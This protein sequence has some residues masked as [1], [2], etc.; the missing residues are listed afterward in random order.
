MKSNLCNI[1]I[2]FWNPGKSSC[3]V[4]QLLGND[5]FIC[6]LSLVQYCAV[7]HVYQH[8]VLCQFYTSSWA[9]L[10]AHMKILGGR[11]KCQQHNTYWPHGYFSNGYDSWMSRQMRMFI[12]V[13]FWW[14]RIIETQQSCLTLSAENLG[15]SRTYSLGSLYHL[16]LVRVVQWRMY[17]SIH[18][19]VLLSC[20]KCTHEDVGGKESANNKHIQ[21]VHWFSYLT[22]RALC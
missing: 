3:I 16:P 11:R 4:C 15:M 7:A 14:T 2:G 22:W 1:S 10:N 6:H 21:A 19:C 9:A 13:N 8:P 12:H 17:I 5:S 18:C 20:S